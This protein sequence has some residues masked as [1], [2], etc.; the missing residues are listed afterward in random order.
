MAELQQRTLEEVLFGP[1][2][3]RPGEAGFDLAQAISALC[4]RARTQAAH[5]SA[6]RETPRPAPDGRRRE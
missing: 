5:S 3:R 4:R 6:V 2:T 1:R